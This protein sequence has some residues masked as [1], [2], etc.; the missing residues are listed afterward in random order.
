M[1]HTD[2]PFDS[3]NDLC[4]EEST[5]I[6]TLQMRKQSQGFKWPAQSQTT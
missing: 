2:A 5:I 4:K 6:F 3:P 1:L